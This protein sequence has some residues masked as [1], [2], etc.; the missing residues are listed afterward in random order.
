MSVCRRNKVLVCYQALPRQR[1][2]TPS[3]SSCTPCLEGMHC[4]KHYSCCNNH[5]ADPVAQWAQWRQVMPTYQQAQTTQPKACCTNFESSEKEEPIQ[6]CIHAAN[7][8]ERTVHR[9][10]KLLT[11]LVQYIPMLLYQRYRCQHVATLKVS[12]PLLPLY[13]DHVMFCVGIFCPCY[14]RLQLLK[15]ACCACITPAAALLGAGSL[16]PGPGR[17]LQAASTSRCTHQFMRHPPLVLQS[18]TLQKRCLRQSRAR[19]RWQCC[20]AL[21]GNMIMKFTCARRQLAAV[22]KKM[23]ATAL[24]IVSAHK[25]AAHADNLLT[26]MPAVPAHL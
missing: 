7:W 1:S 18:A 16:S 26:C 4:R 10:R 22:L 2:G 20:Y 21:I 15:T 5:P 23:S 24:L 3:A 9:K 13:Y 17:D 25:A 8:G 6:C 11:C 14:C 19:R 12:Q